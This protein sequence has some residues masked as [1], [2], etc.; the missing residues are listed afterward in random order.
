M[1]QDCLAQ[2]VLRVHLMKLKKSFSSSGADSVSC[3]LGR[4]G[5][6]PHIKPLRTEPQFTT[7]PTCVSVTS[8]FSLFSGVPTSVHPLI[9]LSLGLDVWQS[10]FSIQEIP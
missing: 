2:S 4:G 5:R 1:S 8:T 9:R 10:G 7:Q 3:S 6:G